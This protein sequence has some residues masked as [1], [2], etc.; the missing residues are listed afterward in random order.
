MQNRKVTLEDIAWN[1]EHYFD[2]G[3]SLSN[4]EDWDNAIAAYT[5]AIEL[6]PHYTMAYDSRGEA[7]CRKEDYGRAIAD[8][9][10]AIKIARTES[11]FYYHRGIAYAGKKDYD[12]GIADITHAINSDLKTHI[13]YQ[14]YGYGYSV[15]GDIY[16]AKGQKDLA[17]KD[18]EQCIYLGDKRLVW[19]KLEKILGKKYELHAITYDGR[20]SYM[21][22]YHAIRDMEI[23]DIGKAIK[24]AKKELKKE[25]FDFL[26]PGDRK[27][28]K[29]ELGK[30]KISGEDSKENLNQVFQK[31]DEII[32]D[33]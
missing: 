11:S 19:D 10:R 8:F 18:Y 4:T 31:I 20:I 21:L 7:Y 5:K 32:G 22:L 25:I 9:N 1:A 17:I 29:R 3:E 26:T 15:R 27:E 33:V 23:S 14:S 24:Y 16:A 28:L 30:L 2:Q 13:Y 6:S 12:K